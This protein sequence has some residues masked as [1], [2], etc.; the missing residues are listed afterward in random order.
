MKALVVL[1]VTTFFLAGCTGAVVTTRNPRI[2][3]G[4]PVK[5]ILYYGYKIV[6]KKGILDRIRQTKTGE[7]THS[8]YEPVD[9]TKYC[10]P[11]VVVEYVPVAD[12]TNPYVIHYEPALFETRKFAVTLDKGMLASVN[13]ES[14]PGH[15]SAVEALQVLSSVRE[16]VL[17]GI[18]KQSDSSVDKIMANVTGEHS[19]SSAIRCSAKD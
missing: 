8:M 6:E 9:S 14:T 5:G 3:D 1:S 19:S 2:V 17:D 7:I 15:K 4:V 18:Q 12:Y 11:V 10:E 13:S 16:D